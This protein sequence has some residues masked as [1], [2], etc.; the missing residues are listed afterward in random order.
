MTPVKWNVQNPVK[1]F[2]GRKEILDEIH[3]QLHQSNDCKNKPIILSGIG[4]IGK[5]QTAAMYIK[6][7]GH[8]Y[9]NIIW[10]NAL[11]FQ[12]SLWGLLKFIGITAPNNASVE[13]LSQ[14]LSKEIQNSAS[15]IVMD[16]LIDE[17]VQDFMKIIR[18][19]QS[20]TKVSFLVT[21]QLGNLDIDDY[22]IFKVP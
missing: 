3:S 9:V 14:L 11:D 5:T 4:G 22:H 20:I 16:D 18:N 7:H 21:S 15:L 17:N 19:L 12:Q 10:L 1:N 6:N 13:T 8:M 2:H